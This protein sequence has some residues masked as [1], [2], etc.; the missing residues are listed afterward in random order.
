MHLLILS[1]NPNWQGNNAILADSGSLQVKWRYLAKVT[2]NKRNTKKVD[3][4]ITLLGNSPLF[5]GI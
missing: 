1:L 2:G 5:D 3:D 4:V